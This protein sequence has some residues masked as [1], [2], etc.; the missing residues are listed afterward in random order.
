MSVFAKNK[1]EGLTESQD[2]LGMSALE[3]NVYDAVIKM[4]YHSKSVNGAEAINFEFTINGRS[5]K[6]TVY[7]TSREGK[8]YYVDKQDA[9]V[10][11]PLPGFTIV[12]DI[13]MCATEKELA[14]QDD[15]AEEKTIKIWDNDAKAELPQKAL[16]LTGLLNKPVTLAIWQNL[17]NKSEK[18]DKGVYVPTADTKITNS[19]EKVFHTESGLSMVEARNGHDATFKDKWIEKNA[20]KQRDQRTIKD[21]SAGASGRPTRG[22]SASAPQPTGSGASGTAG[23]GTPSRSLFGKK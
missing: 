15:E 11:H 9:N 2:R 14:D 6:E 20:G 12:D 3:T 19:I 10:H 7:Y 1:K 8:N 17:E 13:C 5:Y 21:G 4:A 22:G 23:A 16:V 18:N